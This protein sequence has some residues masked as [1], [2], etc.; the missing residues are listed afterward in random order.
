MLKKNAKRLRQRRLHIRKVLNGTAERPRLVVYRSNRHIYAQFVNDTSGETLSGCS[1]MTP[2]LRKQIKPEMT[3][4][5]E[6]KLVGSQIGE[7]AKSK[8]IK[9]VS[10]DRNGRQY[11]GRIRALA[12]AAR[13][14]G[15]EF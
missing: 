7:I 4:V 11:H 5:D 12:E 8:G 6:A 1:T 10:F 13:K 14:S 3:K 9:K 2:D 15:L